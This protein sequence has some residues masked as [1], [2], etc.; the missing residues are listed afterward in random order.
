MS[1]YLD[2]LFEDE[3]DIDDLSEMLIDFQ[4]FMLSEKSHI[5]KYNKIRKM[6]NEILESM[7]NYIT[8][9]KYDIQKYTQI[10]NSDL[11]KVTD[12]I[13]ID[14]HENNPNDLNIILE[15][16]VYDNHPMIQSITDI[17]LKTNRLK[18][19]E[20]IRLLEAMKKSKVSIFK[21]V[22][23]DTD[24]GYVTYEDIFTKEQIKIIDITYT[25]FYRISDNKDVYLYNRIITYD[26][27]S[28]TTG[29]NCSF[30]PGNKK[31]KEYIKS[32]K[33]ARSSSFINCLALY[34]IYKHSK[35]ID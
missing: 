19:L 22:A 9:G 10:I 12:K 32:N 20:K 35:K 6:H 31:L 21:I 27:I 30:T 4:K 3:E 24:E 13:K 5:K 23:V 1:K 26:D 15:L 16:F 25:A 2:E 14:L 7:L 18:N 34:D 33:F 11:K 29:L 17:Y 28:F 8:S